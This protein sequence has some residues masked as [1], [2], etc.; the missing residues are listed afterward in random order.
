[1]SEAL[2]DAFLENRAEQL[3]LDVTDLFIV[4]PFFARISIFG[5]KKSVRILGGRG[6]G[7]TIFIRYFCHSTSFSPKKKQL[8]DSS[9]NSVG[10]YFRPDTGFCS[11]M[12]P[13]WLGSFELAKT[14]FSHYVALQLIIELCAAINSIEQAD[15]A[16]G[17][18]NIGSLQLSNALKIHFANKIESLDELSDFVETEMAI[19][20][21]W[22]QNPKHTEQPVMLSFT[23]VLTI[24][25]KAISKHEKRLSDFSLR[26]FVDEFENL[27]ELQRSIICDAIKHPKDNFIVHI[28]HKRDAVTDFKTSSEERISVIHDIREIDLEDE[29]SNTSEFELLAAELVLLRLERKGV[30]F[31]CDVFDKS[32][33]N[34]PKYLQDRLARDYRSQVVTTV[35][36]ILPE[37]T[38]PDIAKV[39]LSD[40]PLLRRLKEMIERGL[41]MFKLEKKYPV[42]K[43][44]DEAKPEASI[45]LGALLNRRT[46]DPETII[47]AYKK[48]SQ[49]EADPFYKVGGWIDNNLYGC[50]FHLY[51]G[52]PKRPNILYAG[53]DRFCRLAS[54][55]LR[56]FQELCHV[57]LL[58]A[59]ERSPA[60]EVSG[61]LI[62]DYDTQARAV[63][64]VSDGLF[65]SISQ[66]GFHGDKLLEV[67]RRL[68]QLFEV[69]NRRRSQSETEINHFSIDE[70]DR[71]NLSDASKQLLKEAKVWSVLYEEKETKSKGGAEVAQADWILNQIYCP[72]F[73]ISYRKRK[74]LSLK[75]GQVHIILHGSHEQFEAL[76]KNAVAEEITDPSVGTN[77]Q[78]F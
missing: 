71:S 26:I 78:L 55:N 57:S 13:D 8:P 76:L 70:A 31:D 74:K 14:T 35:R 52:L 69:Y 24:L 73:N 23:T 39:V 60:T 67:T 72:H 16:A 20:E 53:F 75:A 10:L 48:A 4:P 42:D 65:N 61:Q 17:P 54:P 12:N 36:E 56:F 59:Y 27:V 21:R 62:V 64:S 47:A 49:T 11:L 32:R 43:L 5:D 63:K 9:L 33:L 38:A 44:L 25:A 41:A 7:K 66:L 30:T 77:I 22:V 28:A 29:I 6:C 51:A 2:A 19:L 34:D 15:F 46:Q 45:V 40:A 1:M 68:G 18:I 50:L 37:L 58:L 3:P